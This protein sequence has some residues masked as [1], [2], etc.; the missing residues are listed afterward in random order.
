M[1]IVSYQLRAKRRWRREKTGFDLDDI[2]QL[3]KGGIDI[4]VTAGP[5]SSSGRPTLVALQR[6]LEEVSSSMAAFSKVH[7][8][9]C[10]RH[11]AGL[12]IVGN[13]WDDYQTDLVH[14]I[15]SIRGMRSLRAAV[16][17]E[18]QWLERVS[19]MDK[20]SIACFALTFPPFGCI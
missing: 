19:R 5:S 14:H 18:L 8:A 12:P 6:S 4:M 1:K 3:C 2:G 9:W 15:G 16:Q 10:M 13:A 11:Q 17:K 7:V 20:S